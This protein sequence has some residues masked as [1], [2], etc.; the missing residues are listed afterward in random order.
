MLSWDQYLLLSN[1]MLNNGEMKA[2][3]MMTQGQTERETE[4]GTEYRHR[5]ELTLDSVPVFS[6]LM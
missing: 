3:N 6:E 2:E 5:K 1:Q 4:K